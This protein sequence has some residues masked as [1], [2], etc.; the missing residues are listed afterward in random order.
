MRERDREYDKDK[1]KINIDIQTITLGGLY[2][3][4]EEIILDSLMEISGILRRNVVRHYKNK[5]VSMRDSCSLLQFPSRVRSG[6][7]RQT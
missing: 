4:L 2:V 1:L 7:L 5:V 6:F 3:N